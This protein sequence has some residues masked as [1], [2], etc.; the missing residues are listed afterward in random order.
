MKY[1]ESGYFVNTVPNTPSITWS[2]SAKQVRTHDAMNFGSMDDYFAE[3]ILDDRMRCLNFIPRSGHT[4]DVEVLKSCS[5]HVTDLDNINVE[6][7]F[8]SDDDGMSASLSIDCGPKGMR[9]VLHEEKV[10]FIEDI[11]CFIVAHRSDSE[12]PTTEYRVYVPYRTLA[13]DVLNYLLTASIIAK[14]VVPKPTPKIGLL[15]QDDDGL[16]VALSAVNVPDIANLD[17]TYGEGF[18]EVSEDV[19]SNI[20][21]AE[22]SGLMIF[23]GDAGTGKTTYIK[24][25]SGQT[26]KMF[27]YIPSYMVTSITQPSFMKMFLSLKNTVFVIEDAEE[28][29]GHRRAG[30]DSVVSTLLN[31]T[32]GILADTL[33]CIF[34]ATFNTDLSNIDP[35][36]LR[37]GRLLVRHKFNKLTVEE[38]N[39]YLLE[40]DIQGHEVDEPKTL[41]EL[42]HLTSTVTDNTAEIEAKGQLPFGFNASN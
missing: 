40:N 13:K 37:P 29:L 8:T 11:E 36:L 22:Q 35:A 42:T 14:P 31:L 5:T 15:V 4:L 23:H 2:H 28:S 34:I 18:N 33:N 12:A 30:G 27:I 25:L 16:D 9:L 3:Q 39:R 6:R 1:F 19:L 21:G 26:D 7:V 20:N 10:Y 38:S 41:A 32:D 24:W 17:V